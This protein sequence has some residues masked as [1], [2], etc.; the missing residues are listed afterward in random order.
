MKKNTV[1]FK[2]ASFILV[3]VI[4]LAAFTACD[5]SGNN[6]DGTTVADTDNTD[7]AQSGENISSDSSSS[8]N[9]TSGNENIELFTF[10]IE[11]FN[12]VNYAYVSGVTDAGKAMTSLEIPEKYGDAE[13][14]G[15]DKNCFKECD[16]LETLTV[17][18]NV[19]EWGPALFTG[20]NK[21]NRVIMDYGKLV[22]AI[23]ADPTIA[24]DFS[25]ATAFNNTVYG[26]NSI[27]ENAPSVRFI[28]K[29]QKTY[30]FF[31]VDYT[32]SVYADLFEIEK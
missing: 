6:T 4:F 14:C 21:L 20:C 22:S 16:K 13:V 3:S 31:L 17:H 27:V 15:L 1:F 8:G 9:D 26:E 23:A 10:N 18:S 29:D 30:D 12:G 2:I 25:A 5:N 24:E 32:W 19:L 11:T 28:F 7:A